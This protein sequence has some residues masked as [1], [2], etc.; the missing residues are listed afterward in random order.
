MFSKTSETYRRQNY[1]IHIA[2]IL[3]MKIMEQQQTMHLNIINE[4]ETQF[5]LCKLGVK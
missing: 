2:S 5:K 1:N 3:L 4:L